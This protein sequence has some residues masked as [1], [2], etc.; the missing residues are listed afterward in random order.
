MPS[1]FLKALAVS[2]GAAAERDDLVV[3]AQAAAIGVGRFQDVRDAHAA[4]VA[5]RDRRAER[6]VIDDPAALQAA[7]EILDLV[8]RDGVADADVHAAALFEAAAAVDA[9]QFAVGVEQRAAGVAGVDRGVGLDAVGVFQQRAGRLLVAVRAGDDAVGHGRLKIGGQ[10]ERIADGE[11]PVADLHL[12]A[13]GHLGGGKVVAA[14]QLDQGHVAGRIDADDHRV[15][16]PAVGHAALHV[17]AGGLDDV[18]V[19][20]RVAVGRDHHARAAAVAFVG[21][22][23]D[24][25]FGGLLNRGDAGLLGVEHGLRHFGRAAAKRQSKQRKQ[26]RSTTMRA[27]A[28]FREPR[29]AQVEL[30]ADVLA[31]GRVERDREAPHA[32]DIQVDRQRP[33]A[34]VGRET[35]GASSS[36]PSPRITRSKRPGSDD[37]IVDAG[38]G[39]EPAKALR[40]AIDELRRA[41]Q[42]QAVVEPLAADAETGRPERRAGAD[43]ETRG[44]ICT[45]WPRAAG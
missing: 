9:D 21:E 14:Q 20:Q 39:A 31:V 19:R 1:T 3:V 23:G 6:G 26:L 36:L 25:G 30:V 41:V 28:S 4:A 8:D 38:H 16:Q 42:R 45:S 11:A 37:R 32:G 35:R 18:E 29:F 10:Q 2:I 43:A 13:V 27:A 33:A 15:V 24:R 7:E 44:R 34:A 5:H 22:D 40:H 12:V 17:A